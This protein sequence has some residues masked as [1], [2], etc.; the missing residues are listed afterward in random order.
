MSDRSIFE[1]AKLFGKQVDRVKSVPFT[2]LNPTKITVPNDQSGLL[3]KVATSSANATKFP[4]KFLPKDYYDTTWQIKQDLNNDS[5]F[6]GRRG[7][8]NAKSATARP[9]KMTKH[10]MDYLK[11]KRDAEEYSGY[12]T[13]QA[14]KYNLNDPATRDWFEKRCP[15][16][17]SMREALIDEQ[18]DL[19]SRMAKIKLRGP[20]TDD[21]LKMEYFVERGLLELPKG[22]IWSP[23]EWMANVAGV[24]LTKVD[25]DTGYEQIL[26]FNNQQY[27]KGIFNPTRP[28]TPATGA[29]VPNLY[30][31]SDIR[32]TPNTNY[33]GPA[34]AI[35]TI[36]PNYAVAYGG[37]N[38]IGNRD[39]EPDYINIMKQNNARAQAAAR[40]SVLPI[41]RSSMQGVVP[42]QSPY[43]QVPQNNNNNNIIINNSSP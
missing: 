7:V 37:R 41:G 11:R 18:V 42:Y 29:W 9:M 26:N 30:D 4:A 14:N 40:S 25:N 12:L 17:F 2:I 13:W 31:R 6:M 36:A 3:S 24:D 35:S 27:R 21:D 20:K 16:Y 19:A 15:Q 34:G 28:I 33:V 10:D 22:P 32:G 38:L 39:N 23:Y 43:G 8:Y 1:Q 5:R